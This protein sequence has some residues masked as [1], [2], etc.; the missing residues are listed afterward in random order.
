MFSGKNLASFTGLPRREGRAAII[1]SMYRW[2]TLVQNQCTNLKGK[3]HVI[4]VG[5]HADKVKEMREDPRAKK[6]IFAP[7]IKKFP[8]F[9]FTG[10]IPMDCRY[11]DSNDMNIVRKQ[12]QKSSAFLRSPETISLNA[13]TFYIYLAENFQAV[14]LKVVQQRIH[15]DLDQTHE[16]EKMADILSF[17]PT[18]LTRL[19]DICD[20]LSKVGL[21][22]FL[23]NN[24]SYENSFLICDSKNC[25]RMSLGQYLL[26]STSASTANS[27]QALE[28][29]LCRNF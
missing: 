15:I 27:P 13:H 20:Q 19:V 9:E 16:S 11:A 24:S 18:T 22:L 29:C 6:N 17:I 2:L 3:A 28:W 4:V 12:I 7:I 25:S 10:F 26:L 8:K 23:H 5:S 21:L 1:D 14:S